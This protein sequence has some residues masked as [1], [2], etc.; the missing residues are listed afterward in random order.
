MC[1]YVAN[2]GT[3]TGHELAVMQQLV[4]AADASN[5]AIKGLMGWPGLLDSANSLLAVH[6]LERAH[7]P[8]V[9]PDSYDEIQF[10]SNVFHV[11]ASSQDQGRQAALYAERVLHKTHAAIIVDPSDSYSRC[12]T[13]GFL[14]RFEE[15]GNKVVAIETYSTGHTSA[16]TLA[17]GL[18]DALTTHPDFIYF[19]GGTVEG[20]LLLAE[21]SNSASSLHLLGG[22]KLYPFVGF[23]ANARPG[24]DRLAFT[25]SAY[26]D[27]LSAK[28]IKALYALDFDAQDPDRVRE[29]GYSRP[30]GDA[31]L[32][33]DAMETLITAYTNAAGIQSL[34]QALS[35]VRVEGASHTRISFTPLHELDDQKLFMLYIDQQEQ[36]R[37]SII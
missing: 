6:M 16:Q 12:L 10:A 22:D 32:S 8:I 20:S 5:G 37:V 7:L 14:Q 11:T 18:Q 9:S 29:Y 3:N 15:D 25:S 17:P 28:H 21:M 2:I 27:A 36:I 33:Y 23:S 35:S 34:Q 26:A 19:A 30:D 1:V 13:E 4:N 24:F 31:I